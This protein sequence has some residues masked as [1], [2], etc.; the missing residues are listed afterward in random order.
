MESCGVRSSAV[1][2]IQKRG[3][4]RGPFIQESKFEMTKH[5]HIARNG[6]CNYLN[7]VACVYRYRQLSLTTVE[8]NLSGNDVNYPSFCPKVSSIT[9]GFVQ[10]RTD[11]FLLSG[12]LA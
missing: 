2:P 11:Y 4:A 9:A 8:L 7:P 3:R 12:Q 10:E 5:C 1:V 6:C